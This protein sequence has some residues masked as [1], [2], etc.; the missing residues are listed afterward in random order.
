MNEKNEIEKGPKLTVEQ[1]QEVG[2]A[3]A[4]A[5]SSQ[6]SAGTNVLKEALT[7]TR[8]MC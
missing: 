7:K 2:M 8:P 5:Q 6:Q 1:A 3:D 4:T